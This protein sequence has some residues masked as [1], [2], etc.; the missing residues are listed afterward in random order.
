MAIHVAMPNNVG[1]R[2]ETMVHLKLPLSFWMVM[3][4]VEH[5][6][7]IRIKTTAHIAVVMV[8][9][10]APR[11]EPIDAKLSVD[12]RTPPDVYIIRA[13][14][15]MI[16]LAGIPKRKAESMVPSSPIT[17]PSGSRKLMRY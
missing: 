14:G 8:Q 13:M 11:I 7:C 15:N 6:Q 3:S 10:L 9:P 17:L 12:V 4:V 1:K 16:S 5:G 2:N